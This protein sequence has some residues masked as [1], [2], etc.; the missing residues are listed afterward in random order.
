MTNDAMSVDFDAV[1]ADADKTSAILW[2]RLISVADGSFAMVD[3][4]AAGKDGNGEYIMDDRV[5]VYAVGLPIGFGVWGV[6]I[7][8]GGRSWSWHKEFALEMARGIT[9]GAMSD[10]MKEMLFDGVDTAGHNAVYSLPMLLASTPQEMTDSL[11]G[12]LSANLWA[13]DGQESRD[14]LDARWTALLKEGENSA[15]A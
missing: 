15:L 7:Y 2:R 5:K 8:G 14:N 4:Q 10:K 13:I 3:C 1:A 11:L 9:Q 12:L 6:S